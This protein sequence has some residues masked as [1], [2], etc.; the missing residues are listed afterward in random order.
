MSNFF[1]PEFNNES[2][3][4]PWNASLEPTKAIIPQLDANR[5]LTGSVGEEVNIPTLTPEAYDNMILPDAALTRMA[6]AVST[7]SNSSLPDSSVDLLTGQAMSEVYGD[8]SKFAADPD[9]AAKLNVAFGENWDATG[10]KALAEGWF[11]GDCSY[12]PPVKVVSS[13]EIDGANGAFAEATDTIYLSKEFLARNAANPAAV[14]DVLLEEIGHSVDSRLN[15][16]DSPGDEGAIFAAVVQGKE[17]SEGELQGLKSEDDRGTVLFNG[18]TI[19]IEKADDYYDQNWGGEIFDWSSGQI[20]SKGFYPFTR[21]DGDAI[22]SR[23][24]ISRNWR[25]G[26][27]GISNG[28]LGSDKFGV[29]FY[30]KAYFEGGKTYNF[31]V[32]AD[33][34]YQIGAIPVN[35]NQWANISGQDWNWLNDA[36]GGKKYTFTPE[37]TGKYWVYAGY[38]EKDGA[39][40]FNISWEPTIS[41]S[42][43]VTKGSESYPITIQRFDGS[44]D[45][46]NR[47]TWLV[48]HGFG[49][50]PGNVGDQGLPQAIDGYQ[51]NDQVL[52]VDWS[53][54]TK[55]HGKWFP[56]V[57]GWIPNVAEAAKNKLNEWGI[58]KDNINIV[59]QSFGSYVG[60]EIAN[61]LGGINKFVALDPAQYLGG[62]SLPD[63]RKFKDVSKWSWA[64][65]S[66]NLGD[67]NA[68]KTADESFAVNLTGTNDQHNDVMG[69]FATL[70][71]KEFPN[72]FGKLF[73]LD[74]MNG[75]DKPWSIDNE[76]TWFNP[77]N[78][79]AELSGNKSSNTWSIDSSFRLDNGA[80][81]AY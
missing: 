10:A 43:T 75:N 38:A 59:G 70:I 81:I 57:A 47:P 40:S 1:T 3:I 17:L 48:I 78:Y 35:G 66:S 8:L 44:S 69:F 45:I 54:I 24:A 26:N 53:E 55:D 27:P 60:W 46:Q 37:T 63:N 77:D 74:R 22:S 16:T 31:S 4:A 25:D 52:M 65:K 39:A 71:E 18:Q 13:A 51:Q 56:D 12:I 19:S 6:S 32:T 9:F 29:N 30:T 62:Y 15:V 61:R 14:A 42:A 28:V 36:Y 21:N 11:Q 20:E 2:A 80:I 73:S 79:E 76:N 49:H 41:N 7:D 5:V 34:Y 72:D 23:N 67:D 68:A 33:D 64:F 58:S 50:D